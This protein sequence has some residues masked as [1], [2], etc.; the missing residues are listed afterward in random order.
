MAT[1]VFL[2]FP[3]AVGIAASLVRVG[4]LIGDQ[5]PIDANHS[6]HTSYFLSSIIQAVL[7]AVLLPCKD[8][9]GDLFSSDEEVSHQ[10]SE[11]IPI[12]CIFMMGDAIQAT[13]GGVLRGL[14]RQKL[15]LWL[16]TRLLD[17]SS[18]PWSN[19]DLCG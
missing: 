18:A 6:S 3:F 8:I 4:Q 19:I 2:S 5:K 14:G 1:F 12:S 13:T 7:I 10:V 9:L 15:V 16:N 17:L 11:L